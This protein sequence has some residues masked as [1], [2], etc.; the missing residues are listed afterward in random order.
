M[1]DAVRIHG[2]NCFLAEKVNDMK[3][4][5]SKEKPQS[6]PT[7]D[8]VQAGEKGKSGKSKKRKKQR[9][10]NDLEVYSD[11]ALKQDLGNTKE[12][13][14]RPLKEGN[15]KG[16]KRETVNA[17]EKPKSQKKEQASGTSAES[18]ND[19]T[20]Y[21]FTKYRIRLIVVRSCLYLAEPSK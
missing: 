16:N 3:G 9:V 5:D 10:E 18:G 12:E 6:F 8:A 14:V 20:P 11:K 13:L 15:S 2:I 1:S 21:I 19:H 17:K 4:N 7:D